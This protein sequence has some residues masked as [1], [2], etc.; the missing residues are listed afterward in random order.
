MEKINSKIKISNN[1]S[2]VRLISA[3]L[4][5]RIIGRSTF[6]PTSIL[7]PTLRGIFDKLESEKKFYN[8][9]YT[10]SYQCGKIFWKNYWYL[11]IRKVNKQ[12]LWIKK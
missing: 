6:D 3:I 11:I 4:A 2:F 9:I 5:F 8:R 10:L 7:A 12:L 1:S